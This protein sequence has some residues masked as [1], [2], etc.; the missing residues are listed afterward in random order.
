MK[1][2]IESKLVKNQTRVYG[3]K[4]FVEDGET[5]RITA[6]ARYDDQCGNGHN[7]FSLTADIES[8]SGNRWQDYS[9]GCCHEEIEKHFPELAPF[10]KSTGT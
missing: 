7:S 3:P 8:K 5:F 1:T 2:K 4:I 10:I 9:G 6:T